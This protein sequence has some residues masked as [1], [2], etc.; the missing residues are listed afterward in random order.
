MIAS[1]M[2]FG[3]LVGVL[4]A[5]ATR[6]LEGAL[7]AARLPTRWVWLGGLLALAAL[8]AAAPLR[9]RETVVLPARV[10]SVGPTRAEPV[11]AA[12]PL[13]DRVRDALRAPLRMAV[14][15]G[16]KAGVP[17]LVVWALLSAGLYAAGLVTLRRA[18]VARRPW[19]HR[20]VAGV[21]VRVSP[22]TG[23][24]VLGVRRPEVVVP[25]W[26]LET[27]DEEQR[28]VVLHE[29]EHVRA[30][31][32]RL[33]AAAA[34]LAALLPWNPAAWWM[35]RRLRLA[36]EVDCDGRVLGRGVRPSSYGSVLLRV[37]GR[38]PA[39]TLAAPAMA[40]TASHLERRL[41]A[42]SKPIPRF[43][44]L[45]TAALAVLGLAA[46]AAACETRMPTTAEVEAMDAASAERRIRP[47][48]AG[49]AAYLIDGRAAT[50]EEAHAIAPAQIAQIEVRK[51][52][53]GTGEIRITT[54]AYADANGIRRQSAPGEEVVV[55]GEGRP[56]TEIATFE[57]LI[58]IDGVVATS[59]QAAALEPSRIVSVEVVKGDA[60]AAQHPDP[61]ARNGV[62]RITTA[63]PSRRP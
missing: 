54:L 49:D 36:V 31:D 47:M 22:A 60:A 34:A 30:G 5:A 38:G 58:L 35:L 1:W 33:L 14:P 25:A 62:I 57:G 12:P 51:T 53:S 44:A 43:G 13:L 10:A 41:R 17:L 40:G 48:L 45:R 3:M 20:V 42:M 4:L 55:T 8:M 56:R 39:L 28:L 50:A 16:E 29:E 24:A 23:P 59:A 15:M 2:V 21:P 32:P 63:T 37:A 11:L 26:L 52:E 18:A 7:R 46:V 9:P 27:D 6:L 61:R 19:G